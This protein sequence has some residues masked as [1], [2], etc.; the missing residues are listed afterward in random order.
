MLFYFCLSFS[1]LQSTWNSFLLWPP[2]ILRGPS[3]VSPTV[4]ASF[5]K[6]NVLPPLIYMTDCIL[7]DESLSCCSWTLGSISVFFLPVLVQH[8]FSYFG[9]WIFISGR[10]SPLPHSSRGSSLTLVWFI[11]RFVSGHW[12]KG[13]ELPVMGHFLPRT[14]ITN[15]DQHIRLC[16]RLRPLSFLLSYLLSSLLCSVKHSITV[17]H[18]LTKLHNI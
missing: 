16:I 14:H 8:C 2:I 15:T 11:F 1:G 5:M 7:R 4:S 18:T 3:V 9:F 12:G 17:L 13:N 6:K 10:A